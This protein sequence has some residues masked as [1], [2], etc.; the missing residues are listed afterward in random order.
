MI[1]TRRTVLAAALAVAACGPKS[2][3]G[4][5]RLRIGYQ[6]A[7]VLYLAK[8][9]GS[10]EAALKPMGYDVEWTEFASGP[11]L[12]EAINS[13][14]VDFGSVGECPAAL[15]QAAGTAFQYVA[16]QPVTGANQGLIVPASSKATT[17][18]DLKGKRI[19]FTRGSSAHIFAVDA[20][21]S[22]NLDLSDIT[23]VYLAPADA[24]SAFNSGR[25]DGWIIWDPYFS[26]SQADGARVVLTGER[27]PKTSMFFIATKP[28]VASNAEALK[29]L[30]STLSAEAEWGNANTAEYG[31]IISDATGLSADLLAASV[32][33]GPLGVRPLTPET[34]ALQQNV[35]DKLLKLDILPKP[36]RIDDAVWA[37]WK[38]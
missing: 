20:L 29:I 14:S 22:A 10:V 37:D 26:L 23:P 11:A 6:K 35:A 9:R 16:S 31:R 18:G 7:G 32:R 13:E 34:I 2:P 30:L 33:R 36:V 24:A 4:S 21:A 8:S 1:T 38:G 19:A 5:G 28:F 25:L 12:M 27:L 17:I 15:A 3:G